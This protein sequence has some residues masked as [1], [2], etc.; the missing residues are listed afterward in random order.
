MAF[1]EIADMKIYLISKFNTKKTDQQLV[2]EKS[3][4]V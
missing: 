1:K 3:I 4:I 2:L